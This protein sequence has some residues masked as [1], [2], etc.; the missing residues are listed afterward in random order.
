MNYFYLVEEPNPLDSS[1]V[2][3]P[4]TR[5][6]TIPIIPEESEEA[7]DT[8]SDPSLNQSNGMVICSVGQA[9]RIHCTIM[10]SIIPNLHRCLTRKVCVKPYFY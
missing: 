9:T 6:E 4:D 1:D 8:T 7:M 2:E 10:K 5:G 3:N